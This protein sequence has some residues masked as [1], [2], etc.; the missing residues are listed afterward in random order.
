MRTNKIFYEHLYDR[1][2][3]AV[4]LS[5]EP[6][7]EAGICLEL[8]QT[9]FFPTGGGQS[10]DLGTIA[11]E[12]GTVCQVIEVHEDDIDDENYV[13]HELGFDSPAQRDSA[14]EELKVGSR[15]KLTIDWDRRFDNMQ[16]HCGEHI[17]SGIFYREYGGVNRGFHMGDDYMTI[18]ISLE[19]KPEYTELTYDMCKHV[20]LCANEVIWADAPV[21]RRVYATRSECEDLP[22]RKALAI[23]KNISI[24]C[25]GSVENAADC[26]ACCGTHPA[27][28]GQVGLIK[29]FK[30]EVNKGMFRVYCEAGRRAY[31]D[32]EFKHDFFTSMA[33]RYSATN[34]TIYEQISRE[35]A[36]ISAVRN[37]LYQLKRSIIKERAGAVNGF[38]FAGNA[39]ID[40]SQDGAVRTTDGFNLAFPTDEEATVKKSILVKEYNDFSIDDLFEIEKQLDKAL[41]PKLIIFVSRK[42]HACILIS[43]GKDV[44][45]GKLV[46]DNAGIYGGKGG[47]RN[48][49]ARAI[50]E[51]DE[52][53]DMFIKLI[54]THLIGKYSE[55]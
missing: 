50:F 21:I 45:C 25:V 4:I 38:L 11:A 36:K 30:V 2:A 53:L 43:D 52:N 7:G 39:I 49:S 24:V 40:R 51:N 55:I 3:E 32:Y 10:C 42:M 54:K 28:A 31:R 6:K 48:E 15:V 13:W 37:E 27:T 12:S 47:G 9:L 14:L 41:L 18:D 5:A 46:K 35:D 23:E 1:E 20:E 16:R 8:D 26:V 44:V 34:D 17:L 22:L 29:I 33:N 19:D